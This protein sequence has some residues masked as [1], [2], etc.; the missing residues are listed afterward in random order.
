MKIGPRTVLIVVDMQVD[1]IT[2]SLAVP[3]A[4]QII[5]TV[6]DYIKLFE[7]KEAK[8]VFTRDWHPSLPILLGSR[9]MGGPSLLTTSTT[10]SRLLWTS[11]QL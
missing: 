5:T 1:F 8:I 2:G 11:L 6:N 3:N 9:S 4:D 10:T 7:E